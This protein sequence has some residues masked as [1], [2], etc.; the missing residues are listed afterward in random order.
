MDR[1]T[2]STILREAIVAAVAAFRAN[3]PSEAPYAFALIGGQSANYLGYAVATD[4]GLLRTVA[5]YE[6]LG[7]RYQ[8][9]EWERFDNREQLA[10]WLRWANP[11][12]GWYY[13]D[14]PE[15]LDKAREQLLEAAPFVDDIAYEE[16]C[17]DV[18]ATL[19]DLPA[20]QHQA[21]DCNL[22]VGFTWGEDPRDFLRTATRCNPYR[23]VI[24]FWTEHW[25]ADELDRRI[26]TPS[27]P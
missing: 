6:N 21:N 2:F 10:I 25:Q 22:V 3:H 7:Y 18:L 14:F 8:A 1:V 15:R 24:Q 12:D 19:Q 27:H 5:H 11:D 16:F 4:A 17:T 9:W 13:E 20:W 23:K 26:K